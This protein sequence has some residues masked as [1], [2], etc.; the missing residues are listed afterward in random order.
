MKKMRFYLTLYFTKF[1]IKFMK[2]LGFN[3]TNTPGEIAL[4]L[5]PDILGY[6]KPAKTTIVVTGTNG[7]TSTNN[8]LSTTLKNCGYSV[9]DNGFGS[10]ILSGIVSVLITYCDLKGVCHQDYACLEVDE[11]SS[12]KIFKYLTADYLICTNLQRDSLMRNANVDFIFNIINNSID[13]R[14][15]LVLNGDD[16]ISSQLGKG[17]N[18]RYFFSVKQQE[19]EISRDNLVKDIVVCPN[20]GEN[21]TWDFVRYHSIGIGHCERCC[22]HNEKAQFVFEK[23]ENNLVTFNVDGD[24]KKFPLVGYRTTDYYNQSAV[25][26]VLSLCGINYDE[27]YNA[28]TNTKVPTSRFT[29]YTFNGIEV[30]SILSKGMN[31][32]AVSSSLDVVNKDPRKKAVVLYLDDGHETKSS[33]EKICWIYDVDFEFLKNCNVSSI[34]IGGKRC[35]DYL[36][37]MLYGGIDPSIIKTSFNPALTA[38][39]LDVSDIE[40]VYILYDMYD[41]PNYKKIFENVKNACLKRGLK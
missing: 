35:D 6:L 11:R 32:I 7:K 22:F 20:C 5:C 38:N 15:V 19:N 9:I 34:S 33:S 28:F 10:N 39:D 4:K 3:A 27:L 12:A 29:S 31:P 25:I 8:I 14:T 21:L 24:I 17:K 36:V 23:C 1:V 30:L 41:I 37:R 2:L 26:S 40:A 16:L 13:K 18:Q